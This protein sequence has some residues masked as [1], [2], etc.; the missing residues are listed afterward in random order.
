MSA[1]IAGRV[2][3]NDLD[4]EGVVL[5]AIMLDKA[6]LD[7]CREWVRPADFFADA[8]RRIYEAA[9]ELE[10]EGKVPTV[11]AVAG[12]LR[13]RGV[14]NQVGGTPYLA[15]LCDATPSF[16]H[17]DQFAKRIA[18]KARL[19]AVIATCST[20]AAEGYGDV[21]DVPEWL[22]TVEARVYEVTQ[23]GHRDET[24]TLLGEAARETLDTARAMRDRKGGITGYSTGIFWFDKLTD[25]L[26]PGN[27]YTLAARPG[28]GKTALA[29]QIAAH[30]ARG[31]QAQRWCAAQPRR[32]VVFVSIEMPKA[33][34]VPRVL[35]QDSNIDA[36]MIARGKLTDQQWKDLA[37]SVERC[38]KMPMAIDEAG[39]QTLASIRS[40][41]RRGL[42]R[43]R[44]KF[45]DLPIGLIVVDY[46]QIVSGDDASKR[47]NKENEISEI[48]GGLRRMAK[49]FA[50][51]L[52]MLSQ[53]NRECE[54]RPDKRPLLSDLRDSGSIEQDSFGV[55]FLYRD[56]LY[57]K[58]SEPLDGS[59][60]ILVRKI[61]QNGTT[62]V[63]HLRFTGE[64][65]NFYHEQASATDYSEF[66]D[67]ADNYR[68]GQ[69]GEQD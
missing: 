14:L 44:K 19:R 40:S 15:Q 11:P 43:L 41:V 37:A 48:S 22:Q 10:S 39:T 13:D 65:M 69:Y 64:T 8:N 55:F 29:M 63:A 6:A 25:G 2:P 4:A 21:G 16:A 31:S 7:I 23:Q 5:S 28:Q 38:G 12:F 35:A 53:L 62:G 26:H 24:M 50:C 57:K 52:L 42:A 67:I 61:R 34:L 54:K 27:L 30:V 18:E 46:I 20:F 58:E 1:N 33:Q 45:G 17:V 47:R 32:L 60:E 56:D 49:E 36:K 9:C 66:D 3:P 68:G 51:P 59:A